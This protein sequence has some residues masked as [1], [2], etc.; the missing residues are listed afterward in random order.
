MKWFVIGWFEFGL[1]RKVFVVFFNV[2]IIKGWFD[3]EYL[4]I[5]IFCMYIVKVFVKCLDCVID[6]YLFFFRINFCGNYLESD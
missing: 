2:V 6:F 5:F 4:K 3:L 1:R